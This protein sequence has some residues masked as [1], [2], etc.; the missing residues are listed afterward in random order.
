MSK[1]RKNFKNQV[2]VKVMCLAL[3]LLMLSSVIV[4][5]VTLPQSCSENTAKAAITITTKADF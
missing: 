2:W 3:A 4:M 1:S 5:I